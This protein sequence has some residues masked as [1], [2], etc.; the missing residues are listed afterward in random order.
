MVH[1]LMA[2]KDSK[3]YQAGQMNLPEAWTAVAGDSTIPG[4]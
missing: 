2:Y 1:L 4:F 3:K